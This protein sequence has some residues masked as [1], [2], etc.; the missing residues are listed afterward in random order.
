MFVSDYHKDREPTEHERRC[1][2]SPTHSPS[3]MIRKRIKWMGV[4]RRLPPGRETIALAPPPP[5]NH[6]R[7][8]PAAWNLGMPQWDEVA[9]HSLPGPEGI[10]L[11]IERLEP[12]MHAN[13][14][15]TSAFQDQRNQ[16]GVGQ[17]GCTEQDIFDGAK[18]IIHIQCKTR[19]QWEQ[20]TW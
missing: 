8:L 3:T 15:L 19:D 2:R 6:I 10:S 4:R 7:D 16:Q 18:R 11:Q 20:A 1:P 17:I 14:I 9:K 12:V 5:V 13:P